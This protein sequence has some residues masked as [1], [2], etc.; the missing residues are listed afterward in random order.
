MGNGM[1]LAPPE[2][3]S[4]QLA[5]YPSYRRTGVYWLP[6]VPAHWSAKR[7]KFVC[8][9]NPSKAEISHLSRETDISFVPMEKASV[10]GKLSLD[11]TRPLSEVW[12]GYT[13][14]RDGDVLVAKITPCFENGKGAY[15]Q[16]LVNGVGFGTTEFHVLRPAPY[17]LAEFLFYLTKSHPFREM[18]TQFM[19]GVAGQQ[20]VSDD[21]I[22]NLVIGLPSPEEQRAVV[23][24]LD[25]ETVR[26][27][28]MIAKKERLIALLEDK[29]ISLVSQAVTKGLN[30][31][32][33]T[34][35][36]S[37]PWLGTIPVNWE[38]RKNARLFRERDER[39]YPDL[40]L[41]NVSIH[42]GVSVREF[43]ET[44]IEW[45]ATDWNTYKRTLKGDIAYNKM[46]MWQ[47]AVGVTPTDGLVSPDYTVAVPLRD[48]DPA[49]YAYLF[50][51]SFYKVEIN[52][53]SHGIVSDRNRLYWD[54]FKDMLS[55]YPPYE[56]QLRIVEYL[57]R[58]TSDIDRLVASLRKS[59]DKLL[60]Y[61][62]ALISAAV[63]GKIDV[64]TSV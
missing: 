64:R 21:F 24:F 41:L 4:T 7:I 17:L 6:K 54:G 22:R 51:T 19:S 38:V 42:T 57:N 50:R 5:P 16:G 45:T 59:M 43:S 47:G 40:P 11:E 60:E 28:K 10:E 44:R 23:A 9:L 62:I 63:T 1:T 25:R 30:P 55:L 61:R 12:S 37:I 2:I 32:S 29:R 52:R 14:F 46:R 48:V 13:Y 18:G 27:N 34:K 31:A 35:D 36:S 3:I 26:I 56:E 33:A 8:I 20:R 53:N 49:Y 15:C 58:V 39:G